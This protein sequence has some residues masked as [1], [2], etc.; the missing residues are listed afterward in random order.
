MDP[1]TIGVLLKTLLA[2]AGV[3]VTLLVLVLLGIGYG[4]LFIARSVAGLFDKILAAR[5]KER[6]AFIAQ[7]ATVVRQL[8]EQR[9]EHDQ[10]TLAALTNIAAMQ[11]NTASVQERTANELGR[12]RD[13]TGA[14]L[15]GIS[16]DLRE[17]KGQRDS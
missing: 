16:L 7:Q 15:N 10:R 17:I 13:E 2:S 14:K 9:A 11:A 4:F 1:Y 12:F 5:D 3:K 8:M 6:E